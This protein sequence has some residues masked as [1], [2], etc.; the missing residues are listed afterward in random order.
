ML[1]GKHPSYGA[2]GGSNL[3]SSSGESDQVC[4][5]SLT[6]DG[7]DRDLL[8]EVAAEMGRTLEQDEVHIAYGD[9]TWTLK[10]E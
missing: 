9:R 10:G 2:T 7:T 3:L 4:L 1:L 8:D 6:E 5:R